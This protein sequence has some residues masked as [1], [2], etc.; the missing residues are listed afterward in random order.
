MHLLKL[1]SDKWIAFPEFVHSPLGQH[2]PCYWLIP[3]YI[4]L[5]PQL[6]SGQ[7]RVVSIP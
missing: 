3:G 5:D 2:V 6:N 7:L 4:S 1:P